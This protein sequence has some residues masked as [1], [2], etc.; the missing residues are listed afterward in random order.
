MIRQRALEPLTVEGLLAVLGVSRSVLERRF[1]DH[2]DRTPKTE[3]LRVQ[4]NR[5]K[6]LLVMTDLPLAE[7]APK[8]GFSH[9]EH[10]STL[11]K[12]KVGQTPGKFRESSHH[13]PRSE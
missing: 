11:F 7:I 2:L 6:E 4:L 10:L 8:A 13:R 1:N 12:I 9:P 3:I 5:V